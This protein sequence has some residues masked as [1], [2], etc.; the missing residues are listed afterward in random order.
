MKNVLIALA[1]MGSFA[2]AGAAHAVEPIKGSLTFGSSAMSNT[3][4]FTGVSTGKRVHH[5]FQNE[6]TGAQ[7]A[8]ELYA[9]EADGS[10][11]LLSRRLVDQN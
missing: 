4:G 6:V 8:K 2:V 7:T 10:L 5:Q 3:F 9:I 1:V 11:R